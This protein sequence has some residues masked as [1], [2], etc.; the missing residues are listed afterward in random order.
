MPT[1]TP[2]ENAPTG[3]PRTT[4]RNRLAVATLWLP[5]V[6]TSITATLWYDRLPA[7][8]PRQWN[9][10]GVTSTTDTEIMIGISGGLALLGAI[11]GLVALSDAAARIRRGLVLVAGFTAGMGAG[12]WFV[13]AGL[14]I[15]TGSPEPD[16]GA[17]P[18]LAVLACAYGFVPFLLASGAAPDREPAAPAASAALPLGATESGAWYTTLTVPMFVVL[19]AVAIVAA[20]G[21][22]AYSVTTD[23]AGTSAAVALVLV[24]GVGLTFARLRVTVD[25]RGL[26]VVSSLFRLPLKRIALTEVAVARAEPLRP[27]EWGGFGYRIL[28]GRSAV[29]LAGGPAIVVER[30]NG[31]VFAVT[32]PEA[33][34]P[35]A[36]LTTLSSR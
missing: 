25:R 21:V 30:H 28:P 35:A 18:L 15:A 26:R 17:W 3:A 14:V 22:G 31:T 9:G 10:A 4:W 5:V 34:L 20:V 23:S 33:E 27:L 16:A 2:A 8:L 11:A 13:S 32:V 19:T 7:V 36:L 6:A 29:V 1:Q 24:A 12:I